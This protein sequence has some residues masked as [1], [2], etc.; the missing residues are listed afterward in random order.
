[1]ILFTECIGLRENQ[2]EDSRQW[3]VRIILQDLIRCPGPDFTSGRIGH[4]QNAIRRD[5]ESITGTTRFGLGESGGGH[6]LTA[7]AAASEF[8]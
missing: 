3:L 4:F 8:Q 2:F 7:A 6:G 1:M 5:R